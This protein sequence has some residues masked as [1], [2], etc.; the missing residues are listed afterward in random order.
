MRRNILS[1]FMKQG[2]KSYFVKAKNEAMRNI[3]FVSFTQH[4]LAFT[5]DDG[6]RKPQIHK[7]FEFRKGGTEI[8][9]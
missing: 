3:F 9:D 6:K 7:V 4:L 5:N 2:E 1:V 8:V